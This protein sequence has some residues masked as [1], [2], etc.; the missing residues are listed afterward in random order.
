MEPA[1]VPDHVDTKSDS[2][3]PP[4]RYRELSQRQVS[5]LRRIHLFFT[6]E[7]IANMLIPLINQQCGISLRSL[8][9]LVTNYAK[10]HNI[11]CRARNQTMFNIYHGYKVALTHFRRRNFD[12]FR[13]RSRIELVVADGTSSMAWTSLVSLLPLLM[14]TYRPS[15]L[16]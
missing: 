3:I 8:D 16:L 2:H 6:P 9:W 5:I 11:V 12:P 4:F 13:R 15:R 10:K 1:C 14:K 7:I